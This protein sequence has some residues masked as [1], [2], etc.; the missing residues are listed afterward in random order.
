MSNELSTY[1][2]RDKPENPRGYTLQ[3]F[4]DNSLSP[5]PDFSSSCSLSFREGKIG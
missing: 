3:V 4:R 2:K 1:V 5:H